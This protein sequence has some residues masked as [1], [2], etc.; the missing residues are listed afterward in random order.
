MVF[1]LCFAFL[2]F[3]PNRYKPP[4]SFLLE[5]VYGDLRKSL[6][7][8]RKALQALEQTTVRNRFKCLQQFRQTLIANWLM[9]SKTSEL[10]TLTGCFAKKKNSEVC[11]QRPT[12]AP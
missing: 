10:F 4:L 3:L 12:D 7:G 9:A 11:F 1:V 2:L 5:P 8:M 6:Q